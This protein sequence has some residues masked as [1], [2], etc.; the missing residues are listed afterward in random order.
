VILQAGGKTSKYDRRIPKYGNLQEFIRPALPPDAG[1]PAAGG[2][3]FSPGRLRFTKAD[4]PARRR[5][6]ES[7]A[8]GRLSRMGIVPSRREPKSA[9]LSPARM[10][11]GSGLRSSP[12]LHESSVFRIRPPASKSRLAER[13]FQSPTRG[14]ALCASRSRNRGS[15]ALRSFSDPKCWSNRRY[16]VLVVWFE[17]PPSFRKEH[18]GTSALLVF[19]VRRRRRYFGVKQR[20]PFLTFRRPR[21]PSQQGP[22][23]MGP[24]G[25]LNGLSSPSGVRGLRFGAWPR[26]ALSLGGRLRSFFRCS[27]C[28]DRFVFNVLDQV[29]QVR[30]VLW[31][32]SC[33]EGGASLTAR[34]CLPRVALLDRPDIK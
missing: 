26:K 11:A 31:N 34:R 15:L 14:R 8:V 13:G 9:A 32:P 5:L 30:L 17:M 29:E 18:R 20:M 10:C 7:A 3:T 19:L 4:W 21:W 6:H 23:G 27:S 22:L 24:A 16:S 1:A 25:R 28:A 33:C 2:G 12:I